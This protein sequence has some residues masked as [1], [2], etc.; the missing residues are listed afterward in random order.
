M[1][2]KRKRKPSGGQKVTQNA[3]TRGFYSRALD[4]TEQ[5][6]FELAGDVHGIDDE[7]TLLRVKIKALVEHDPENVQL[8]MKA[9]T[10]LARLVTTRY[11][12]TREEKK[13]LGEAIGNVLKEIAL[14]L[15]I[16][17][18]SGIAK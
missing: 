18:G 4:A 3:K 17:I 8:L 5:L 1:P 15:G 12:I 16:G 6:D 14:P 13:K 10:T 11:N 2:E 9:T 7:I